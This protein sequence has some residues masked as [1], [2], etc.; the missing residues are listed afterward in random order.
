LSVFKIVVNQKELLQV[1]AELEQ[2]I[3]AR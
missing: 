3:A 1:F 2:E